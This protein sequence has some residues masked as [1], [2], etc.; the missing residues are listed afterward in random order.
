MVPLA[1]FL[2]TGWAW[3]WSSPVGSGPDDDYHMASIWCPTP[4]ETSGCLAGYDDSGNAIIHIPNSIGPRACY[5]QHPD[6][7]GGCQRDVEREV[8]TT[9]VDNGGY[10]GGYYD[11][12][13]WFVGPDTH[14]S[15]YS[16]R[17]FNVILAG[18]L[19]A[20]TAAVS[21]KSARLPVI[22]GMIVGLVPLG[23]FLVASV[24]PSA[25]AIIGVAVAWGSTHALIA[26]HS[27]RW[28]R[29]GAVLL[30]LLG[31]TIAAVSRGDAG[32]FVVVVTAGYLILQYRRGAPRIAIFGVVLA[33]LIGLIGFMSAGQSASGLTQ[34]WI[35]GGSL[36]GFSLLIR[37]IRDLPLLF[38]GMFGYQWG[39]GWLDTS[40]PSITAVA[41]LMVVGGILFVGTQRIS[42]R[43]GL[44]LMMLFGAASALALWTLQLSNTTVGNQVQPRY[45]L[46][47][48]LVFCMVLFVDENHSERSIHFPVA[49]RWLVWTFLVIAQCFALQRNIRRYITGIDV[50]GFNLNVAVEWWEAP[51]QP[52]TLWVLGTLGFAMF[53]AALLYVGR[54]TEAEGSAAED[55]EPTP[56]RATAQA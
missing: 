43:K 21:G 32:A 3:A 44:I 40:L 50:D 54:P 28:K 31:A 38:G 56:K 13:H 27:A 47:L 16:M 12:M 19:F 25:W 51:V 1:G 39:L 10:P 42:W 48:I 45:L 6:E 15:V 41:M 37:N 4:L 24:N 11:F 26:P 46:P 23:I 52:M 36:T 7:S 20:A 9:R 35:D 18:L 33:S 8:Q 14:Q 49:T 55:L 53:A 17:V 2:L 22:G 30:L 29:I 34:P 5:A